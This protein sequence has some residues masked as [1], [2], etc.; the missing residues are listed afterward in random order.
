MADRAYAVVQTFQSAAV[1]DGNG[2]AMDVGGLSG[3]GVQVEGITTATVTFEGTVDGSTWYAL[4]AMN[5]SDGAKATNT[6][7]DGLFLVPVAGLDQLRC[8]IS[9]Y[10]GG[11]ITVSGKGVVNPASVE[12]AAVVLA[13]N[14]GVDIGDVDVLSIAAGT[15]AIGDVGVKSYTTIAS[16]ELIGV[17]SAA[18]M[19]SV[20][21]KLVRF[22][23]QWQNA[24][25]AYVGVSGVTKRDGSTDTTTGF[26]LGPG[27]DSGWLPTSNV[28]G[29]YYICD[30]ATD[31]LTYLTMT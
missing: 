10:S 11:T 23:A 16:G 15:N 22:K 18:Q 14:S 9:G 2:T 21:C 12:L 30:A 3:V 17:T 7:A 25:N 6:A 28:N 19:P 8:R 27:D 31:C 26:E 1:A 20:A 4:Q 24:G 5:V 29:F 13:A